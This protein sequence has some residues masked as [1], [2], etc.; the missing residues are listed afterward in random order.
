MKASRHA[1]LAASVWTQRNNDSNAGCEL[2]GTCEDNEAHFVNV[3]YFFQR[4]QAR[5]SIRHVSGKVKSPVQHLT[6]CLN[7]ESSFVL[8]METGS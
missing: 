4:I 3:L 6:V 5:Q 2:T 7:R 8:I 1:R